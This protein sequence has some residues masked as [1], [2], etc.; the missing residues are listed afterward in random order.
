MSQETV[1]MCEF[2]EENRTHSDFKEDTLVGDLS[3]AELAR[4]N[5]TLL[6]RLTTQPLVHLHTH[7][8]TH[9]I[10]TAVNEREASQTV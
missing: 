9:N 2:E 6:R 10:H 1:G 3:A 5:D 8:H 4:L 7:R